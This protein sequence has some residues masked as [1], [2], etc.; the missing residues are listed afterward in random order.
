VVWTKALR[1]QHLKRRHKRL[2]EDLQIFNISPRHKIKRSPRKS[3]KKYKDDM[4]VVTLVAHQWRTDGPV[5][6]WTMYADSSAKW[7]SSSWRTEPVWCAL[8]R[9]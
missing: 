9:V 7:L 3:L 5:A 2:L 6:H 4:S 1:M 8:D